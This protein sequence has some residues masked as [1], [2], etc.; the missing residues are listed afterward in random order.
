MR[1]ML[2]AAGQRAVQRQR[3]WQDHVWQ[4][5]LEGGWQP[6]PGL[7]QGGDAR[8]VRNLCILRFS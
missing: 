1:Q 2:Q 4:V 5:W 8:W 3:R 7:L 6:L